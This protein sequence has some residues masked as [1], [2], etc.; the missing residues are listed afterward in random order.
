MTFREKIV[1]LQREFFA[2]RY[3]SKRS[4]EFWHLMDSLSD[5]EV[6]LWT[7]RATKIKSNFINEPWDSN[8]WYQTNN[9]I[10]YYKTRDPMTQMPWSK[11]QKRFCTFQILKFWDDL[12]SIYCFI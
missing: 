10:H 2:D 9:I 1:T 7:E 3:N 8:D 12:E 6:I 4:K 5:Q 11:S